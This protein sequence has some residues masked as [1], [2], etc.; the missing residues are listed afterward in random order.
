MDVSYDCLYVIVL[1]TQRE[2]ERNTLETFI[3]VM[4]ITWPFKLLS[5]ALNEIYINTH[6]SY[7]EMKH[8]PMPSS[9]VGINQQRQKHND[10]AFC[11]VF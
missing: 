7:E 9:R 3:N 2:L 4:T 11:V 5:T 1:T 10:F 6:Y 8:L